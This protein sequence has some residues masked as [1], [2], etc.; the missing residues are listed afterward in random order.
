LG[1]GIAAIPIGIAERG[2][3]NMAVYLMT[4][5]AISYMSQEVHFPVA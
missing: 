1:N 4:N 3:S 5:G 2:K